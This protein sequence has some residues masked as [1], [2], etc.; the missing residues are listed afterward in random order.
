MKRNEELLLTADRDHAELVPDLVDPSH[1]VQDCD[2]LASNRLGRNG[3]TEGGRAVVDGYEEVE[4]L[5][6][7][8]G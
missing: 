6:A 5:Q 8:V 2:S 4:R 1:L 7:G 3:A